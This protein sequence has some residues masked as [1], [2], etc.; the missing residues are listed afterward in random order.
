MQKGTSTKALW[1]L[2]DNRKHYAQI[3]E[4]RS[5][6]L[7]KQGKFLEKHNTLKLVEIEIKTQNSPKCL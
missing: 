6:N 2:K 4:H 3:Y 5:N 7:E 1:M